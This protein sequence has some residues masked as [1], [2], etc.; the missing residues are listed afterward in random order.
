MNRSSITT[1]LLVLTLLTSGCNRALRQKPNPAS[2]NA[3]S[4]PVHTEASASNP[5][6]AVNA[7]GRHDHTLTIGGETREFIV[8]VPQ[9]KDTHAQVP[10]VIMLHGTSGDGLRFYNISGWKEKADQE[11]FIAVFPS[12]LAYCFYE[13]E[14]R[15]GDFNDR[16]ERKVT[17]KWDAGPLGGETLPLCSAE[18]IASLNPEEQALVDHPLADDMA[19]FQALFDFLETNYSVN[20]KRIYVAGFSNGAQMAGRLAVEMSKRVAAAVTSAAPLAVSGSSAR[21]IS[22]VLTYGNE[23]ENFVRYNN[24]QP[25]TL[26]ETLIQHPQ[27]K[28]LLVKRWLDALQL[29]DVYEYSE[30]TL[31]GERYVRFTYS[32]SAIGADNSFQLVFIDNLSH[33]YPNGKNHP[34]VA[35]DFLWEFLKQYQLP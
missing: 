10:V 9:M 17:T 15:D 16:N 1:L 18:D 2:Q 34:V 26:D 27:V 29:A 14:N 6:G 5:N 30:G 28:T 3:D 32:T 31:S 12:A 4:T 21:P 20:A 7:P 11:K 22:V 33:E 23:D 35:A 25:F 24:G 19:F 13:D 8:Y